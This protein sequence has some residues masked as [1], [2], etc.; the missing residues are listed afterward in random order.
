MDGMI[1]LKVKEISVFDVYIPA[2]TKEEAKEMFEGNPFEYLENVN[3]KIVDL[4][5]L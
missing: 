5:I 4:E 2:K 1:K 3:E